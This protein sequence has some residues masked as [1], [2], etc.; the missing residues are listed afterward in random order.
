MKLG[1]NVIVLMKSRTNM[2]M[3]HVTTRSLGQIL[4]KDCVCSRD[5]IFGLMFMKHGQSVCLD[6]VLYILKIGHIGS[7]SRSL[8]QIIDDPMLVIKGL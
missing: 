8:D 1:Q 2:K 6:A 3:D 5:H 4:E 7:K